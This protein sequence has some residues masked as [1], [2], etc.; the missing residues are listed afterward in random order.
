MKIP[1]SWLKE[2]VSIPVKVTAE[3]IAQAFVNVGFEVEEI[4]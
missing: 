3:D 4:E 1:L 2:F